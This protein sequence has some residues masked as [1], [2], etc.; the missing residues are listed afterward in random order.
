MFVTSQLHTIFPFGFHCYDA[1]TSVNKTAWMYNELNSV[2]YMWKIT[3]SYYKK[4]EEKKI[5]AA[6]E[7]HILI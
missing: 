5:L 7:Q 4:A 2:K 1:S 3:F 6:P